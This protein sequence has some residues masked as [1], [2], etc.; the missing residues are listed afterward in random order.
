MGNNSVAEN[1][2]GSIFIRLV[3][4]GSQMCEILRNSE[5]IRT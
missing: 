2:H 1:M 4:V 5:R 3:V